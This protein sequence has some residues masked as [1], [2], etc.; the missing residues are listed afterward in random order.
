MITERT[1]M[2]IVFL[3]VNYSWKRISFL[4]RSLLR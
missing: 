2:K 4:K 3:T 1:S